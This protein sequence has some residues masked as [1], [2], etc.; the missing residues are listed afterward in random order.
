MKYTVVLDVGG[1]LATNLTPHM[2][3]LLAKKCNL[4]RAELY[5][6][7]K[8]EIG[9]KLWTSAL[10]EQQFWNWFQQF[11]V[12]LSLEDGREIIT[13][14]LLPLPALEMLKLWSSYA[15]IH[16]MS[17]HVYEWLE[18]ILNP[19][20]DYITSIHVSDKAKLKKPNPDWF[21]HV[22]HTLN[23]NS[24][25]YFVDDSKQNIDAAAL[26]GWNGILADEHHYWITQLTKLLQQ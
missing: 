9:E 18:P 24:T 5:A 14:S 16:I 10:T 15:E 11:N 6:R 8:H 25:I 2:W 26:Y 17:N 4:T 1:V 3:E 12:H 23:S 22:H 13:Q 20:M 21:E 19:Y 7:Y